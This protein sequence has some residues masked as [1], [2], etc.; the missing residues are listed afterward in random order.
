VLELADE[1]WIVKRYRLEN[2]ELMLQ[3]EFLDGGRNELLAS[4][5]W[6]ARPT[7]GWFIRDSEN[8]DNW[9]FVIQ[10]DF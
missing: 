7:S 2:G 6:S 10:K 3:S 5:L 1:Q 9:V 8:R 4:S